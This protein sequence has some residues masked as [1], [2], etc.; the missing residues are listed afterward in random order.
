MYNSI[1]T[2]ELSVKVEPINHLTEQKNGLLTAL[3][4]TFLKVVNAPKERGYK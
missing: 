3:R 2:N 4:A 1:R